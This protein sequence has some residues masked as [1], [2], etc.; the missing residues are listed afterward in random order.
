VHRRAVRQ[1]LAS[2]APPA[3]CRHALVE[4]RIFL[5]IEDGSYWFW[6]IFVLCRG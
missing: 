3:R 4:D 6:W 5:A 1:A 2:A